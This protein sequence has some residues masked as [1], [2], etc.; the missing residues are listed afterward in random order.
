MRVTVF[1]QREIIS[2]RVR[3]GLDYFAT[4]EDNLLDQVWNLVITKVVDPV[5]ASVAVFALLAV[6]RDNDAAFDDGVFGA[7]PFVLVVTDQE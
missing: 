5:S 6:L 2:K 7:L 4:R 1:T 3:A